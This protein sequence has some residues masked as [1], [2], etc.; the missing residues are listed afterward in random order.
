MSCFLAA[1]FGWILAWLYIYI[2]L[3]YIY[4]CIFIV[5]DGHIGLLCKHI[6]FEI[7]YTYIHLEICSYKIPLPLYW[8]WPMSLIPF[9]A[10]WRNPSRCLQSAW[11]SWRWTKLRSLTQQISSCWRSLASESNIPWKWSFN[12]MTLQPYMMLYIYGKMLN[13][14]ITEFGILQGSNRMRDGFGVLCL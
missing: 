3:Y 13:V 8:G 14:L 9:L 10:A 5:I 12:P 11:R 2:E 4:I 6:W 7:V 1:K